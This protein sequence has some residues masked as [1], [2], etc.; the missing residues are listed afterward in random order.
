MSAKEVEK[1]RKISNV[2][3]HFKCVIGRLKDFR[4]MQ[5]IIPI[6]QV[7]LLDNVMIVIVALVNPINSVV[8]N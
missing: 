1:P 6:A 4:I 7:S 8:S 5:S 2:K 3:I